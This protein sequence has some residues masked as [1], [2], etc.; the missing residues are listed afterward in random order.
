[1]IE[2]SDPEVERYIHRLV[3]FRTR[4]G[5]DDH[6]EARMVSDSC[7]NVLDAPL[8]W[9]VDLAEAGEPGSRWCPIITPELR[10]ESD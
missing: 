6:H 9:A 5:I 1:M 10:A 8:T 7:W 2:A 4:K 3:H